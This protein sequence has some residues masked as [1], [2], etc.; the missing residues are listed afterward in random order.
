MDLNKDDF[1]SQI[2]DLGDQVIGSSMVGNQGVDLFQMGKRRRGNLAPLTGVKDSQHAP[3]GLDHA[4][5][6]PDLLQ[7]DVG[8]A[9]LDRQAAS[10]KKSNFNLHFAG[11]VV[12]RLANQGYRIAA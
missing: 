2:P 9:L 7:V 3:A 5:L 11:K 4:A 6:D 1:D 12:I 10:P 8:E